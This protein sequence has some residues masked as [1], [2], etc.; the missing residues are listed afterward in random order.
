MI[1]GVYRLKNSPVE[2][3]A[4]NN[5]RGLEEDVT[6]SDYK[7]KKRFAKGDVR[8]ESGYECKEGSVCG[9]EGKP[10]VNSGAGGCAT[11]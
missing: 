6:T 7:K 9:G 2:T 10:V 8:V 5:A 1:E 11:R 3:S 4:N